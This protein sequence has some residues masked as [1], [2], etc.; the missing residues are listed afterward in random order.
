MAIRFNGFM[1]AARP[2]KERA[3]MRTRKGVPHWV[4]LA[5]IRMEP[6]FNRNRLLIAL[7]APLAVSV[8]G[9]LA[10]SAWGVP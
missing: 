4:K 10:F 6:R 7:G 2:R 3:S 8:S 1:A 9:A 5:R